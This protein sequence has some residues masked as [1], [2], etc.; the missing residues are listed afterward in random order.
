MDSERRWRRSASAVV[1]VVAGVVATDKG[2]GISLRVLVNDSSQFCAWQ[3][4]HSANDTRYIIQLLLQALSGHVGVLSPS[5][6]A[7]GYGVT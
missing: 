3:T 6:K 4:L 7:Q 5:I 2:R 1:A